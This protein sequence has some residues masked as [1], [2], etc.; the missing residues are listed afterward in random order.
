MFAK[1]RER[2]RVTDFCI[3]RMFFLYK[4]V[5]FIVLSTRDERKSPGRVMLR[6]LF[7]DQA[8]LR[9]R[10]ICYIIVFQV[11]ADNGEPIPTRAISHSWLVIWCR[12][13]MIFS[14]ADRKLR[15]DAIET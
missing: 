9:R 10:A 4:T 7:R 6:N 13:T 8:E 5:K 3:V 2:E 14:S 12:N 1:E 11:S 15:R